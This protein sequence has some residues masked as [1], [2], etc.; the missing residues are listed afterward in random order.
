MA[1]YVVIWKIPATINNNNNLYLQDHTSTLYS[2][3]KFY[4][5]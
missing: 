4:E 2:I 5:L 3:A 1:F